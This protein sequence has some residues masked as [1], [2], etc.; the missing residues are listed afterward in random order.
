MENLQALAASLASENERLKSELE[1]ALTLATFTEIAN[2]LGVLTIAG[3]ETEVARLKHALVACAPFILY[4][5]NENENRA[6][7]GAYYGYEL[8]KAAELLTAE[9]GNFQ[10]ETP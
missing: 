10:T 9:I 3:L 5:E 6:A 1:A 8:T 7:M 4:L 2:S